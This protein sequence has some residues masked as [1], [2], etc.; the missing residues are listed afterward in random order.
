MLGYNKERVKV[1][2]EESNL[3][4][5]ATDRYPNPSR[6]AMRLR[7]LLSF[8]ITSVVAGLAAA[9]VV[10]LVN[11]RMLEPQNGDVSSPP[12]SQGASAA[13][14]PD[15]GPVSYARAVARAAPSV[16]N[17]YTTKVGAADRLEP[18]D[19][20]LSRQ[21]HGDRYSVRR[22]R[23]N[24]LGSGVI[25]SP[26]GYLLTNNHIV[27]DA[28][29][30][31]VV[32]AT[33]E[34]VPVRL[35]GKDPE[36]DLAVLK[37]QS[38]ARF[39]SIPLGNSETLSVGDVV[40]AIGNPYG[41]GQT[42]TMGIV[43]ATGRSHL[44]INTYENFIQTDAAINPGNS[45]GA[46]INAHGEMVGISTL[47]FSE[48]GGSQGIGFAIPTA[49]AQGVMEQIVRNGRVV[50]GW[51]GITGQDVT[52]NLVESFALHDADGILVSRVLKDG[53]ADRAGIWPGD[54]ITRIG[55]S[56][57]A[58]IDDVLNIIA[59]TPPGSK[60]R[61]EGWRGDQKLDVYAVVAER[62]AEA[63]HRIRSGRTN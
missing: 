2:P 12:Q 13:I 44:D 6:T 20:P 42:V 8:L 30:I 5:T 21:Y 32:L 22:Q 49:L 31:E 17:I 29:Q 10:F 1:Y 16:V 59:E 28:Q 4:F 15:S 45:G 23:Q 19:S 37:I 18:L 39:P 43:S 63:I 24:S 38:Q 26:D 41:V 58:D 11:P 48:S 36:S 9:F 47:I 55:G 60:M 7:K 57:P 62:P 52:P 54:V 14:F 51:L 25:V 3:N 35:V 50:R 33:G 53:P 27:E 61:V 34:S 40:L 56:I 46:L